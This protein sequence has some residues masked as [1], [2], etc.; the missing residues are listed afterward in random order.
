MVIPHVTYKGIISV[1]FIETQ[2]SKVSA[3][4]N[5]ALW[6]AHVDLQYLTLSTTKL[7]TDSYTQSVIT[8]HINSQFNYSLFFLTLKS[9]TLNCHNNEPDA[10]IFERGFKD[11]F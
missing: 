1:R 3:C 5:I 4:L 2:C 6:Q 11:E 8:T 7:N 9:N 10:E